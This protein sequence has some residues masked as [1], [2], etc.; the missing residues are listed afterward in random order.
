[1]SLLYNMIKQYE[2]RLRQSL[3][4]LIIDCPIIVVK[5]LM[6]SDTLHSV[7]NSMYG[8]WLQLIDPR[9]R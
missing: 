7:H 2:D 3:G 5:K 9:V 4:I 6:P 1:M 8:L